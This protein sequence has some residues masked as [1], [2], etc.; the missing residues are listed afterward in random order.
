M[1]TKHSDHPFF[2]HTK[3]VHKT[4]W[5]TPEYLTEKDW[6]DLRIV[7]RL[8][9]L[10]DLSG[11]IRFVNGESKDFFYR[12][13]GWP[14]GFRY[15]QQSAQMCANVLPFTHEIGKMKKALA[16]HFGTIKVSRVAWN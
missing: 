11:F 13:I 3:Q 1:K 4:A 2:C 12:V 5:E 10:K 8:S 6:R 9:V 14:E 15:C 16:D 7:V